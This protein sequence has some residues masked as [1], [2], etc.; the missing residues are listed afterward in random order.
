MTDAKAFRR[1][2]FELYFDPARLLA[3][4]DDQHLQRIERFLDALAPLHPVLE[5][6]YL[7]GDSLRDAL[8]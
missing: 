5:N 1:Y 3:L 8:S 4:D 6:W 2:I 7:C